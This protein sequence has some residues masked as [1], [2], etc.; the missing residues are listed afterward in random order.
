MIPYARETDPFWLE[1]YNSSAKESVCS[2][3]KFGDPEIKE[4]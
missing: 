3:I 4:K 2:E 1:I